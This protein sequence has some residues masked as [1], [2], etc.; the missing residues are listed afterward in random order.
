MDV[1]Q[2]IGAVIFITKTNGFH[3]FILNSPV[4]Y[5]NGIGRPFPIQNFHKSGK[6]S[7][8]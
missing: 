6:D 1:K 4:V 2:R 3:K 5:L 7:I 8:V